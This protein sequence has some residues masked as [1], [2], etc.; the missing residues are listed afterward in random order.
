MGKIMSKHDSTGAMAA[1]WFG[2][3]GAGKAVDAVFG[4]PGAC[5]QNGA[6]S[7]GQLQAIADALGLPDT[8]T[9][10]DVLIKIEDLKAAVHDA[11]DAAQA[12]GGAR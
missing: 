12:Q 9:H 7:T 6:M 11:E 4:K 5:D 10:Q 1:A 3:P 8:A 2:T